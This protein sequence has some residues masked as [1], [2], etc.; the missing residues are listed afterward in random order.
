[1]LGRKDVFVAAAAADPTT[2]TAVALRSHKGDLTSLVRCAVLSCLRS[3]APVLPS[4]HN[5]QSMSP[6][7]SD[8]QPS[9]QFHRVVAHLAG[10]LA[11]TASRV[12][13]VALLCISTLLGLGMASNDLD[14]PPAHVS[15]RIREPCRECLVMTNFLQPQQPA[16]LRR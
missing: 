16:L 8:C 5:R 10:L 2:A 1:M 7:H 11:S 3:A 9:Y 4:E 14:L 15:D 6:D 12:V 13:F